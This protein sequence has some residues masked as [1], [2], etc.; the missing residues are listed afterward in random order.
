VVTS[1]VQATC[2]SEAR[3]QALLISTDRAR[4]GSRIDGFHDAI[5]FTDRENLTEYHPAFRAAASVDDDVDDSEARVTAAIS[6]TVLLFVSH[7]WE[8][9][10]TRDAVEH[11]AYRVADFTTRKSAVD[12]MRR[13]RSIPA[14]LG[15]PPRSWSA[16]LRIVLG[17]PDPRHAGTPTG[18]GA[19]TRLLS[20]ESLSALLDDPSLTAVIRTAKPKGTAS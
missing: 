6:D 15:L 4:R 10:A 18:Q 3:G 5:R 19:L 14:R 16:L 9:V 11:V 2:V 12:A 7:G 17:H 8:P 1:A 13:D 20:G